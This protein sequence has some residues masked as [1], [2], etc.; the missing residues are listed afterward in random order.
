MTRG[1]VGSAC[2][3]RTSSATRWMTR[4]RRRRAAAPATAARASG[5]RPPPADSAGRSL[6]TASRRTWRLWRRG[7]SAP[8]RPGPTGR[9]QWHD[10]AAGGTRRGV[11]WGRVGVFWGW[12]RAESRIN[13]CCEIARMCCAPSFFS[14][15]RVAP[16]CPFPHS[17]SH[18]VWK[19]FFLLAVAARVWDGDS[20]QRRCGGMV[21]SVGGGA[22]L[23]RTWARFGGRQRMA[24]VG[25]AV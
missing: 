15:L 11:E 2:P 20:G 18:F 16:F 13:L 1:P 6:S 3:T 19:P 5:S 17:T 25:G 21:D 23:V 8:R 7:C 14:S 22:P 12:E 4:W 24:Q 10:P 9:G